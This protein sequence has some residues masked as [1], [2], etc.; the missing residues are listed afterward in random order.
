MAKLHAE[1]F[2]TFALSRY[3]NEKMTVIYSFPETKIFCQ[4][5]N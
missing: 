5:K 1:L 3:I 2:L 4:Q